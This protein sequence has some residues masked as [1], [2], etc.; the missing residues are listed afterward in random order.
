MLAQTWETLTSQPGF[1]LNLTIQHLYIALLAIA[2]ATVLGLI[3][4]VLIAEYKKTSGVTLGLI[5]IL[6]TIPSISLLG[7][8]IPLSGIGNTT[9]I[10]ALIIYAL[11][12][13]VRNTFTGIDEIDP[14]IIEAARGMGSTEAEILRKIKLPLAMPIIVAGF[15]NMAVM[16]IALA[17][18]AAFIGA[19]GLG[20]AIYRGITTNNMA[21][22]IAGS[23]L[24]AALAFF[25][26][27][28][29]GGLA[30]LIECRK[31]KWRHLGIALVSLLLVGLLGALAY[32]AV[33]SLFKSD[34]VVRIATKP[35][36]EQL[37]VGEILAQLIEN[38]TD[39]KVE[40]TAGVGGGTSNIMPA[41][42]AGEFDL[43]PE[44]T[45][46][47]WSQVLGQVTLYAPEMFDT[48]NEMY[49][50]RFD[51]QWL[52]MYGLNNSGALVV[53]RELADRYNLHTFSDLVAVAP[54][55]T[56]GA[57]YDFFVRADS[58]LALQEVY[59]MDFGDRV[60]MDY[61]LLYEAILADKV[62]VIQAGPTDGRLN[63]PTL[64]ALSDDKGAYSNYELGNV[65]R[66]DFLQ[67]H[68][69]IRGPIMM[70]NGQ[71]G[72]AEIIKM[73][74]QVEVE[75]RDPKD[76]A[77]DFLVEKGLLR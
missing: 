30:R 72:D 19:G 53:R 6:Y 47:G 16:T 70:L 13:M 11:L 54:T 46:T 52:G 61:G 14:A 1:F 34:D 20:V 40:M 67:R 68:P 69:E 56:I 50:E 27:W 58:Y 64:A 38:Q 9:A 59:G 60:E 42:E 3:I 21:M 66:N 65:I 23:I 55:L 28:I 18:I 35:M 29:V 36:T 5:N 45:G 22:T 48:M 37:I 24:I 44:Y 2:V 71:I 49:N 12:P 73:N 62:D 25:A 15:R 32:S 77:H 17:G 8:L 31:E 51:M 10:I 57:T 63:D 33:G 39:L 75:G 43:Y 7:L 76:V 41:M 4:G 26:D 74:Y